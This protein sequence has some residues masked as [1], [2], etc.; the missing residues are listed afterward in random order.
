MALAKAAGER[1]SSHPPGEDDEESDDNGPVTMDSANAGVVFSGRPDAPPSRE[2]M[3]Q[4]TKPNFSDP[5]WFKLQPA[6]YWMLVLVLSL[7]L[8]SAA[9]VIALEDK[10]F[11][12]LNPTLMVYFV[13]S[14]GSAYFALWAF[15]LAIAG[16]RQFALT[17]GARLPAS[18]GFPL[19]MAL[20][21]Y[22]VLVLFAMMGY[23]LYQF[24][25]ELHLDVDVDFDNHR[26]AGGAESIAR[27]GSAYAAVSETAPT[28][29][30]ER[31][32]QALLKDGNV[33]GAIAE[34]K[35][36]M[37]Y[38]RFDAA[39]NTRLHALYLQNGDAAA[40]L[41]HGQQWLTALARVQQG[42]Q[43]VAALRA[44]LKIDPNFVVADAD[45]VLPTA[46]A[47]V[48]M[49][50]AALAVKLLKGFDKRYPQHKD[51]PGVFFL[52]AKLMSEQ[53]RQHD[54]AA[55]LLRSVLA[56]FP[57]HAI[58]GEATTYL[59]VLESVAAKSAARA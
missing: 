13:R 3:V 37:R 38:D 54:K 1:A 35:D 15:F 29:P 55:T 59:S 57:D 14:I 28:D 36:Y 9:I 32:I 51:L 25:Q 11:K 5:L 10:F 46:Q 47:A 20:A 8:P 42:P 49:R 58:V 12:A 56:R 2:Q 22:L 21:T 17:A 18:V 45:V 24:H 33:Q 40:T 30:L 23:A 41:A 44:M 26:Q 19:E 52:G 43:A 53:M 39:W 34:V 27:A 4:E 6:W 50:D 31:K 48:Q 16:A 7:M